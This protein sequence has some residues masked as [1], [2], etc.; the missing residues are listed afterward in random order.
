MV[1]TIQVDLLRPPTT[2]EWLVENSFSMVQLRQFCTELNLH[3]PNRFL[4]R[5]QHTV[6][7]LFASG[8]EEFLLKKLDEA[9]PGL[10][11]DMAARTSYQQT[12]AQQRDHGHTEVP[13]DVADEYVHDPS[14][15]LDLP[16]QEEL[17]GLYTDFYTA[18]SSAAVTLET[19]AVCGRERMRAELGTRQLPLTTL[20]NRE[21]LIPK[22]RHEKQELTHGILLARSA[23]ITT[24]PRLEDVQVVVCDSCFSELSTPRQEPPKYSLANGLWYGDVPWQLKCLTF[25]EQLLISRLYPR[26]FVIKL[27]PKDGR[28]HSPDTLQSALKGNITT[29]E[30]NLDKIADMVNGSLMPQLPRVLASVL[31]ITYVGRGHMPKNW[32]KATFRVRRYHVAEALR[33][34]KDNNPSLYGDIVIDEER[35]RRLPEDDV[36]EEIWSF[37]R[38]EPEERIVELERAGYMASEEPQQPEAED[39]VIEGERVALMKEV[40]LTNA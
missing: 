40:T 13:Q 37:V 23:C 9:R 28:P 38:H 20:P 19:C 5:K 32:L 24:G 31:S 2:Y 36:P 6:K 22:Q 26:V 4:K 29:F 35:L 12:Q 33:W 21:R 34:L 27:Y 17:H 3:F 25:P 18:T 16:T 1:E 14:R 30:L 15:F 7:A 39:A 8:A 10:L 11:P